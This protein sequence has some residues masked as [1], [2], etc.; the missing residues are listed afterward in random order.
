[1]SPL[2]RLMATIVCTVVLV[3]GALICVQYIPS[4]FHLEISE[5]K[6]VVPNE[7][8][9]Q[10][11]FHVYAPGPP[12]NYETNARWGFGGIILFDEQRSG[13]TIFPGSFL[14]PESM[15]SDSKT[16]RVDIKVV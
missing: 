8:R 15:T 6:W 1:M 7:G 11:E 13:Y 5:T 10:V 2:I 3:V 12:A 4:P 14:A 16:G 9:K